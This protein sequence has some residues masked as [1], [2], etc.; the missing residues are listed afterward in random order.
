[1]KK[2][3]AVSYYFLKFNN[4]FKEIEKFKK[5]EKIKPIEYKGE[6]VVLAIDQK[7]ANIQIVKKIRELH[8]FL[9]DKDDDEILR[10]AKIYYEGVVD[11]CYLC[12]K[13][14]TPNKP[15]FEIIV[16]KTDTEGRVRI[17]FCSD[18]WLN[19]MDEINL[20]RYSLQKTDEK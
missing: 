14:L 20:R 17:T 19:L 18:C 13:I 4:I 11:D 3:Y 9:Q 7:D 8:P 2:R 16:G 10:C 6:F 15:Y 12:G 1:M 5:D